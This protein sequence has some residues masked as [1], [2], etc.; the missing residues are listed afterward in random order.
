MHGRARKVH[1]REPG[2]KGSCAGRAPD[3][4]SYWNSGKFLTESAC[5]GVHVR[6]HGRACAFSGGAY[7]VHTGVHLEK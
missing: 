1:G 5:T 6:T 2:R 4:V 3:R 7:N